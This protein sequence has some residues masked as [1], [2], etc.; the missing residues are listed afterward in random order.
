ME[1]EEKIND[2][3]I[4]VGLV[5]N[6]DINKQQNTKSASGI[7]PPKMNKLDRILYGGQKPKM[8]MDTKKVL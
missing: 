3:Q 5:D 6:Y 2:I 7:I 1:L 8:F 4:R